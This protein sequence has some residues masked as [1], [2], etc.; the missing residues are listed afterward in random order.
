MMSLF[1]P[2]YFLVAT[3]MGLIRN[4][5][6]GGEEKGPIMNPFFTSFWRRVVTVSGSVEADWRLLQMWLDAGVVMRPGWNP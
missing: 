3:P 4:V 5:G 1:L 6:N 2:E